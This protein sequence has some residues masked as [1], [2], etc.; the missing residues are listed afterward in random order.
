MGLRREVDREGVNAM[1]ETRRQNKLMGKP[2][3]HVAQQSGP[4]EAGKEPVIR[5]VAPGHLSDPATLSAGVKETGTTKTAGA[6]SNK[7][8]CTC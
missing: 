5:D 6:F 2:G 3:R 1:P 8:S 7:Q 4:R